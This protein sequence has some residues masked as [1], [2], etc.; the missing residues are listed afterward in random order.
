MRKLF[1][2]TAIAL[3]GFTTMNAQV[4]KLGAS[5]GLPTGVLGDATSFGL[6]LDAAYLW[7]VADN[8]TVG[9]KAGLI[10]LFGK[11]QTFGGFE[12][13]AQDFVFLPIAATGRIMLGEE[14]LLGTDLGYGIGISPSGVGSG[15]YY[16][17]MAGYAIS[18]AIMIMLSYT[19]ISSDGTTLNTVNAGIEFGL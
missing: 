16:R 14:F 12:V 8:V 13:A 15:I 3:L 4:F 5:A 17:P 1:L 7:E 9:P 19:G 2:L 18:E 10:Y 6:N 11:K